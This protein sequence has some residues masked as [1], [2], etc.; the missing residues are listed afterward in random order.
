MEARLTTFL[1]LPRSIMY[2][3]VHSM[4]MYRCHFLD[5]ADQF[6]VTKTVDCETDADMRATADMLLAACDCSGIEIW[7]CG[8]RVYRVRKIDAAMLAAE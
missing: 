8:R 1:R 5:S 2:A 7:D 4:P 6:V 3:L